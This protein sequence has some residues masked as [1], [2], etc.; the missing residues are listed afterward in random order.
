M[1]EDVPPSCCAVPNWGL[2]CPIH[3]V[4]R[5]QLRDVPMEYALAL[6]EYPE[7]EEQEANQEGSGVV[8][9]LAR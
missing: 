9:H 4:R 5:A 8:G 6:R 1:G 7:Q 2:C 3:C